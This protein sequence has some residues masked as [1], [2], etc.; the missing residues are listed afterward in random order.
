VSVDQLLGSGNGRIVVRT[1]QRL[2]A[3]NAAIAA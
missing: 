3:L 2:G 1:D